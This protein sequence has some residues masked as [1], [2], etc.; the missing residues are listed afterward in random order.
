[1]QKLENLYTETESKL[2]Q[3]A[4]DKEVYEANKEQIEQEHAQFEA[5][6][7]A[8]F[9]KQQALAQQKA[10]EQTRLAQLEKEQKAVLAEQQKQA[11][12]KAQQEAK[13][14]QQQEEAAKKAAEEDAQIDNG[15]KEIEGDEDPFREEQTAVDETVNDN[16]ND[17]DNDNG[18]DGQD[19]LGGDDTQDSFETESTY[20]D[21]DT[22]GTSTGDGSDPNDA[23]GYVAKSRFTWP[24]P[25]YYHISYGVG[26]RW[27]SVHQGIDIWSE[28]IRGH[29]IIAADSGTVI[30][31]S[32]T[33]PHDYGKNGSCGCGGGYGN[34]CIIDHGDGWWTLYGHSEGITVTE[35]QW[36]NKGDVLG[37]VGSTGYSTGPH[38]HFEVRINN[39]PQDPEDYV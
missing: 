37:T 5:D 18:D 19:N 26:P 12:K 29:N 32:N 28:G 15:K 8:L 23:Y 20:S 27:G 38:L 33:C 35:G 34:Y 25:G 14:K 16:G 30:L 39:V 21:A 6:L 9:E 10:D 22:S 1:M 17:N 36:V 11:K 3:L 4:N 31:V 24:V 7:A 13:K 2:D